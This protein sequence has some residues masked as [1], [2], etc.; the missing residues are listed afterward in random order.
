[1]DNKIHN[2]LKQYGINP[3]GYT[4]NKSCII[5]DT[6]NGKYVLKKHNKDLEETFSYLYTRSYD[7][8]P[9]YK[10]IG[11]YDLYE[12][13]D[14][15]PLPKYDSSLEMINL[16]SLLH[17]K[18]T[19]YERIDIDDYKKIYEEVKSKVV[20]LISYYNEINDLIDNEIF[21]SPSNYL[22][23]RNISKVYATLDFCNKGIDNWYDLVKENKKDR[24]T[25]THNNLKLD[26]LLLSSKAYLIS[27]DKV[28]LDFPIND[29]YNFYNNNSD[30]EFSYLYNLY[31]KKYPLHEDERLLLFVLISIPDRIDF[32][33]DELLN[34]K[35]I[36][37][38]LNKIVR[39]EEVIS[40][41]YSND[42][43]EKE[44]NFAK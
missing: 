42:E 15:N 35:K 31:E 8:F 38:M 4:K 3:I 44:H 6:K 9:R 30:V 21:M 26:N 24:K 34:C 17:N 39:T 1:M 5:L 41:Y 16:I 22:L 10:N 18:T 13:I 40:K 2:L 23:V 37:D 14:N 32:T 7:F 19:V 43:N 28:R 33:N 36:K 12:Y 27:W 25:I 11:D 29:L 20:S